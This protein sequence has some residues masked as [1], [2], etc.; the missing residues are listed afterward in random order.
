MAGTG[1]LGRLKRKVASSLARRSTGGRPPTGDR[2][3]DLTGTDGIAV[4]YAPE[5][6]GDADPGEVVWTW[7]AF[8]DDPLQGKDRPVLVLGWDG[9]LLAAV[10]LSSKDHAQRRDAHEWVDVGPGGWDPQHRVSYADANRLLRVEPSAVRREGA[11][12]EQRAFDRVLARVA[13]LHGWT[14]ASTGGAGR[15]DGDD[16]G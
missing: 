6:D 11:A 5:H 2:S 7:V 8:E 14:A 10:P 4:A 9:P 3:A 15:S 1:A 13:Q 12:L 16:H